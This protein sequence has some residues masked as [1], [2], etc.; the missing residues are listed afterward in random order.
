MS[1]SGA[2]EEY[3]GIPSTRCDQCAYGYLFYGRDDIAMTRNNW[4]D[5]VTKNDYWRQLPDGVLVVRENVAYQKPW[6][7]RIV[8][9]MSCGGM[10][11][12][13]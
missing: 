6:W 12:M 11:R 10:L 3:H 8:D 9:K 1:N 13:L 7:K 4:R 2:V 5:V